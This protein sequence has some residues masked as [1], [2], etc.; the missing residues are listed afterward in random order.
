MT[1]HPRA[2]GPGARAALGVLLLV[3]TAA[4]SACGGPRGVSL[5]E[6]AVN[7][8]F[9]DGKDVVASGVVRE[10]GARDDRVEHHY[11][12]QDAEVNRVQ[13]LPADAAAPH[14]GS[15]VEVLG[16]FEYDEDRGRRLHIDTIEAVR[17][18]R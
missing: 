14:T 17:V 3:L 10:F 18:S 6:L 13:L 4:L 9:Y 2:S 7:S 5:T 15:A 11:V 8:E 12:L 1:S 16:E